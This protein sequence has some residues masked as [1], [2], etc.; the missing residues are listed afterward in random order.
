[1]KSEEW[2]K[3]DEA[4]KTIARY[5]IEND[6]A[7]LINTNKIKAELIYNQLNIFNSNKLGYFIFGGLLLIISFIQLFREQNWLGIYAYF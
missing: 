6:R 4:L 1:M 5:Q 7:N 3:A 2:E